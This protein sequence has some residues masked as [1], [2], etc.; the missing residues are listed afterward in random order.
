MPDLVEG[1]VEREAGDDAGQGDGQ[2]DEEAHGL[3]AEERKRCTAKEP[4]VPSTSAMSVASGR[5][6]AGS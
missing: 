1:G 6:L 5:G 4:S 2:H 3:A